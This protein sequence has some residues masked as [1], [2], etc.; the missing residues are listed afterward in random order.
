MIG[1]LLTAKAKALSEEICLRDK[2]YRIMKVFDKQRKIHEPL[3]V[4]G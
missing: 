3:H 2:N 1:F 4:I